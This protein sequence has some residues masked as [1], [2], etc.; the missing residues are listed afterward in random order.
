MKCPTWWA[1][2]Q[3]YGDTQNDEKDG[4]S[5][6]LSS[7][8]W[9][10][11]LLPTSSNFYLGFPS[12][13]KSCSSST[14]N[15]R[16]TSF[17]KP[18]SKTLNRGTISEH[19]SATSGTNIPGNQAIHNARGPEAPKVR[20]LVDLVKKPVGSGHYPGN[21][22]IF[23]YLIF[24]F[25]HHLKSR[26][27]VFFRKTGASTVVKA[28]SHHSPCPCTKIGKAWESKLPAVLN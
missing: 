19:A 17:S 22:Y 28:L 24:F 5:S 1:V 3:N 18:I 14:M 15:R 25:N 13:Q 26:N 16:L 20:N 2:S 9:N 10:I 6:P 27:E 12:P 21:S 8:A 4:F 23:N 7:D 11:T